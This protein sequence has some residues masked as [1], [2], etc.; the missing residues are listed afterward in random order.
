[1][2]E[3]ETGAENIMI[4]NE[5]EQ[6][7]KMDYTCEVCGKPAGCFVIS[8]KI[9]QW[10]HYEDKQVVVHT[11][12]PETPAVSRTVQELPLAVPGDTSPNWIETTISYEQRNFAG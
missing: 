11:R 9:T 7:F 1:M 10:T 4:S 12:F 6:L 3:N 2:V 8:G 5:S